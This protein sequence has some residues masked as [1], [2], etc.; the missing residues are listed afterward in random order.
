VLVDDHEAICERL[1]TTGH[2]VFYS[3]QNGLLFEDDKA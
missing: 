1:R 2:F 3:P